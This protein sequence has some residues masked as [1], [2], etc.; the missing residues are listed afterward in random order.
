LPELS[1][2]VPCYN[3]SEG[4]V[5]TNLRI[6][7]AMEAAMIDFELIFINDG[8][9]DDTL[10]KLLD[11]KKTSNQV[12]IIDFSRNFGHQPAVSAGLANC[13]GDYAVII[14][15]DLQDPPQCI[16]E[17]LNMAIKENADVVYGVRKIRQGETFFKKM[18]AKMFY[19]IM[20]YF[21][22]YEIPVDT[23]DFRLVS[24]PVIEQFNQLK[25]RQKYIRG[26]ISWIGFKQIP[27]YYDREE[28]FAGETHYPFWKMVSFAMRGLLYF[29]KKPLNIA[30]N[31]GI[32]SVVFSLLILVYFLI[33]KI[34]HSETLIQGW[35]SII[36]LIVFFGGIQLLTIGLLGS[37]IGNMFDEVKGRPEYIVKRIKFVDYS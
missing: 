1:I 6:H 26:L 4:I 30:T 28:R 3:E 12:K 9:K 2:I 11:I 36:C 10:A 24:R 18:T 16:P 22:E 37:Y 19:R 31:L 27:Y 14:D 13:I 7:Q 5:E 23:G 17:M 35:T 20:N 29:S 34:F 32:F 33:Q 25:E 8:S 21:S 15:A